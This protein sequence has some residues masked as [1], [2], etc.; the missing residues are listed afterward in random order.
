MLND[1]IAGHIDAFFGTLSTAAPLAQS[2]KLK[3]LAVGSTARSKAVP[4]VP[5]MA[6]SGLPGFRSTSLTIPPP[7]R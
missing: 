4:D 1:L 6:E 2:G 5:A 7:C 3:F